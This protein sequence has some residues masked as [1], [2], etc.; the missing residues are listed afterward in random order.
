MTIKRL[1][2]TTI[3]LFPLFAFA[4]QEVKVSETVKDFSGG[5]KS[6]YV[7]TIPEANIKDINSDWQKMIK[8]DA[9]GKIEDNKSE[10]KASLVTL[11]NV[12][13]VP[14]MIYSR[15][16]EAQGGIQL[17]VWL[18]EGDSFI[19]T[20]YSADKSTA[21]Q[22]YLHDF[23]VQEY[24]AVAKKQL[25]DQQNKQKQLEKIYDG[26]VKDQKNADKEVADA[27][28][29]IEKLKQ[30]NI[31]EEGNIKQAKAN[32]EANIATAASQKDTEAEKKHNKEMQGY[33]KDQEKAENNIKSNNK[34]I[35]RLQDKIKEETANSAKAKDNQGP[36]GSNVDAQ[37][38]QV[39][40]AQDKLNN[41]K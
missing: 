14:L 4:Q 10:V 1:I 11:K 21:V 13:G 29:E 3:Y 37:K 34:R 33:I 12:S 41:I 30:K 17:S 18:M 31:D 2:S 6:S 32:K 22:K 27:Q 8:K 26:F 5:N 40:A 19:S 36:A 38:T 23:G 20:G 35:E 7:L 16:M 39:A 15:T 9:K 24:K 25:E 28:K